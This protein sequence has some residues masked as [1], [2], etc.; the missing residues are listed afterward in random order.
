MFEGL[1]GYTYHAPQSTPSA[2][3]TK[4]S[5]PFKNAL[6]GFDKDSEKTAL[7]RLASHL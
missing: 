3:A 6:R 5:S 7:W 2:P 4:D 1:T